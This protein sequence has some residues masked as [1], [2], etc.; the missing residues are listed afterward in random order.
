[1]VWFR[2]DDGLSSSDWVLRIPRPH[3]MAAVGVWTTAG[4]WAA[5]NE[6]D[7]FVPDYV[8]DE[9]PTA[10]RVALHLVSC[11]VWE[12]V[13]GGFQ[14]ARWAPDQYLATQNEQSRK[15]NAARQARSRQRSNAVTNASPPRTVTP[16]VTTPSPVLSS[17]VLSSPTKQQ[18]PSA[19][20]K[21]D[22][23]FDQFWSAYPRKVGKEA[24][25]KAFRKACTLAPASLITMAAARYAADPNLPEPTYVPHPSTW[26]SGGRWDDGP[27]ATRP[28]FPASGKP[29]LDDKVR[30]TLA[31][32]ARMRAEEEAAEQGIDLL[33]QLQDSFTRHR[34]IGT[35]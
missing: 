5:R 26:L 1:M 13:S 10:S 22:E 18:P 21:V 17:P 12:Q 16:S 6:T 25:R 2:V 32:A 33:G 4:A 23:V 20:P 31:D 29:N 24:A 11:G 7:G 15:A 35:A 9:W 28:L 27:L 3:R 19:A 14:F 34:Q 30:A 8:L